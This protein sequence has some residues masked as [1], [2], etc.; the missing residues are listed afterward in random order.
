VA[1]KSSG[2]EVEKATRKNPTFVF[3][4]PVI[5]AKLTEFVIVKLLAFIRTTK[6]A[7]RMTIFPIIPACSITSLES[8]LI[9][10]MKYSH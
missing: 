8:S 4:N 6:E 7:M 10:E 1:T 2:N 3:P 9:Y 5:L